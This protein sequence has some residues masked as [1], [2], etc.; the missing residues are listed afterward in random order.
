MGRIEAILGSMQ[1]I[2]DFVDK[3]P[4]KLR[5]S[6]SMPNSRL[7]WLLLFP[8][9]RILCVSMSRFATTIMR[10]FEGILHQ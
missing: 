10:L 3:I 1:L 2:F 9:Y 7:K 4:G 8:F 5:V 6:I